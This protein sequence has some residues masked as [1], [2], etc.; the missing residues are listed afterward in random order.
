MGAVSPWFFTHYGA[1]TYNK[2]VSVRLTC[3]VLTRLC[4]LL[5]T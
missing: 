1:D 4:Q 5:T 2:N 3:V